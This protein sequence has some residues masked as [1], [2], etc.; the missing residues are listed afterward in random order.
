MPAKSVH[1]YVAVGSP[2]ARR[3]SKVGIAAN[4]ENRL[5]DLRQTDKRIRIVKTWHRPDDARFV[6]Y[7]VRR[8]FYG[9]HFYGYE[10]FTVPA[11]VLVDA[12]ERAI[13]TVAEG[14]H[15]RSQGMKAAARLAKR[16]AE[17]ERDRQWILEAMQMLEAEMRGK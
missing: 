14:K 5:K 3:G 10:W 8:E 13:V 17:R 15:P 4:M 9:K 11:K 12:V 1:V 6:E 7:T 16:E 2:C